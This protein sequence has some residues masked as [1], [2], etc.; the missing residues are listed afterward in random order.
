MAV[1]VYRRVSKDEQVQSGLGLD[2]QLEQCAGYAQ[3][4]GWRIDAT[5]SDEGVSG[6]IAWRERP[7][8][9]PL[10]L[11]LQRGDIVIAAKLDRVFRNSLDCLQTA[12][13]LQKRGVRLH[14]LDLGGDV[15]GN[16]LAKVFLTMA[17]AFA[18]F[19]RDRISERI[20]DAKLAMRRQG[21]HLGGSRPFG[22]RV[23]AAGQLEPDHHEQRALALLRTQRAAGASYRDLV[24]VLKDEFAIKLSIEGVRRALDRA[25]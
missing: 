15:T 24:R 22:Y 18:E 20:R 9:G 13:D 1:Y 12:D 7:Q 21:R 10:L 4:K 3:M 5:V 19:E 6:G 11:R 2:A 17:A 25:P 14:L 23:T 16:G 8:G